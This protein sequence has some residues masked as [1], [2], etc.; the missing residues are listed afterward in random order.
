MNP[1]RYS[2]VITAHNQSRFAVEAVESAL[3]CAA[4]RAE[5]IVVDD[6]STDETAEVLRGY[7]EQIQFVP[8]TINLGASGARNAG[9]ARANGDYVLFLDGDDVLLPWALDVYDRVI[10]AKKP[11]IILSKMA[12]FDEKVALP[13]AEQW[14][15]QIQIAQYAHLVEKDRNYQPGASAIVIERTAL[16]EVDG[17]S[18]GHNTVEDIDLML[19]LGTTGLTVQVLSPETKGYRVHGANV[20][21]RVPAMTA[22]LFRVMDNENA[23]E[24]PGG[25][26]FRFGRYVVIGAPV[27][28]WVKQASRAKMYGLAGK[29]LWRGWRM[30]GAATARKVYGLVGRISAVETLTLESGAAK[31]RGVRKDLAAGNLDKS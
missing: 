6:A 5:I 11:K 25:A 16:R 9:A 19:K 17:W 12:W 14:P 4:G 28:F 31:G 18:A 22:G 15:A 8:L 2:I 21:H 24:Y 13:T 30:L 26:A 1:P 7:G 10:D 29:I 23:G 20:R 27:R 3:R